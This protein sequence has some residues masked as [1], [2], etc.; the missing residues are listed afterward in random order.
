M[1]FKEMI[2]NISEK[3]FILIIFIISFFVRI[4]F[5]AV[6]GNF[7]N[8]EMYEHGKIADN[9][10]QGNGYKMHWPYPSDSESRLTEHAQ[11]PPFYTA[12]IPPLN[13]YFLS[14]N[15]KVFGKNSTAY[16]MI[17]L[18]HA[19]LSSITVIVIYLIVR[20]I[21]G[22]PPM[23]FIIIIAILNLPEIYSIITF[24]GGPLYHLFALSYILFLIKIFKN[25]SIQNFIFA[26]ISGG[27]IILL[28][29]EF[30]L[31]APFL[32]LLI[33]S[34]KYHKEKLNNLIPRFALSFVIILAI[35]MPWT[36]RNFNIF[37]KFIPVVSHPWHEIWRGSNNQ[38]TGG[39]TAK[40]GDNLWLSDKASP[41]I[42][43]RLDSIEY[44]QQ[45][46][47]KADAV[48]KEEALSY[49]T[50]HK[51][52]AI[53]LA[54]KRLL[55]LWTI[56]IYTV[57]EMNP[58]FIF[59]IMLVFIPLFYLLINKIVN[60]KIKLFSSEYIIFVIIILYYSLLIFLVNYE[61]RYKIFVTVMLLPLS[62]IGL[63]TIISK[64]IKV[65]NDR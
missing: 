3:K 61:S 19:I 37:D 31:L 48:F 34:I 18:F 10:Y 38:A 13:P 54:F 51:S 62:V 63:N 50:H 11:E 42:I 4:A 24:S 23:K 12:F 26:G 15:F 40:Y 59:F 20:E 49:I 36:I 30:F 29:S 47:L 33:F 14:I 45:F 9:I 46:E 1:N 60:M 57:R 52:E 35:V 2:R 39:A 22:T 43:T 8:P 55:F 44:N 64:I 53:V 27:G 17:M 65:K 7:D 56:D 32:M 6:F 28:R 58:I 25:S 5:V 21:S 41:H 16:F